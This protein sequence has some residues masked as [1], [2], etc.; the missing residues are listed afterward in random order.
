MDFKLHLIWSKIYFLAKTALNFSI[1]SGERSIAEITLDT[2][3][4]GAATVGAERL[5]ISVLP[6]LSM[7]IN[8]TG[9]TLIP[10][11]PPP[12][13]LLYAAFPF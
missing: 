12:P 6:S 5:S 10:V 8:A 11:P 9:V 3:S 1:S 13:K 2:V 7:E 4:S